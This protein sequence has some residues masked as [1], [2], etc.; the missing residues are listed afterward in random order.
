M[1]YTVEQVHKSEKISDMWSIFIPRLVH[2]YEGK[3]H[4]NIA[5]TQTVIRQKNGYF[6]HLGYVSVGC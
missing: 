3:G 6:F 4:Y 1:F 2:I 5:W